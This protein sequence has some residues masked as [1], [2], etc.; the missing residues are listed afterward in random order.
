VHSDPDFEAIK[1]AERAYFI[2]RDHDGDGALSQEEFAREV[3]SPGVCNAASQRLASF[4]LAHA[5]RF[6][7]P[8]CSASD[9]HDRAPQLNDVASTW[10]KQYA[11]DATGTEWDSFNVKERKRTFGPSPHKCRTRTSPRSWGSTTDTFWLCA[12][13]QIRMHC[14]GERTG[15]AH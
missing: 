10:D 1:Q 12:G 14:Y 13:Y 5:R 4:V 3:R 2:A 15:R 9:N 8:F 7:R 6:G 11:E